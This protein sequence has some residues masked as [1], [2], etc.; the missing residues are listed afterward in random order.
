MKIVQTFD[1][2]SESNLLTDSFGWYAPEY[3]LMSWA[4]SCLQLK[5]FY[6]NVCL[7]TNE[8]GAKWLGDI[9]QLPYRNIYLSHSAFS[10]PHEDLWALPKIYTYSQQNEPFLHVDGDVF[11]FKAF[12]EDLI[13]QPLIAQN[14][15]VATDYYASVQKQ[16]QQHFRYLPE[17]VSN[18]FKCS[19]PIRAVNA[20]ILGGTDITFY[21]KYT[22][23]AFEYVNRNMDVLSYV[24]VNRL[25]VFVEQHLFCCYA[26][27]CNKP[28]AYLIDK[29]FEDNTYKNLANFWE[30]PYKQS[31]LHLLGEFKKNKFV[32]I[33]MAAT[34][35]HLYPDYYYQ[36]IALFKNENIPLAH[37]YYFKNKYYDKDKLKKYYSD[38]ITIYNNQQ[39]SEKNSLQPFDDILLKFTTLSK[40]HAFIKE[41]IENTPKGNT[42][43][44][45]NELEKD[46][47]DFLDQIVKF[48]QNKRLIQSE[49]FYGRDIKAVHWYRRIFDDSKKSFLKRVIKSD[50][51]E[52]IFTSF[53]WGAL[54]CKCH[55]IG[56][57][58]YKTIKLEKGKYPAILISEADKTGVSIFDLETLEVN[59]LNV[60]TR[61][62]KIETLLHRF[63]DCFETSVIEQNL[64]DIQQLMFKLLKR[65][66]LLKAVKPLKDV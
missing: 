8:K 46:Y 22:D 34:L 58:Y 31:Y 49:F 65:L 38:S 59:L 56:T 15:E 6:H 42:G 36:I 5:K 47:Q 63:K 61:P 54:W 52:V 17:V 43:I 60:M 29:V 45:K 9:L 62:V 20:G 4:L 11:I 44:R 35:R 19:E 51:A 39:K 40:E 66:I 1:I 57:P 64:S 48:L 23:L 18:D 2:S 21:K 27:F 25:N 14:E 26:K 33:Q 30:T 12:S 55:Q 13:Q 50:E 53:N 32:C 3:H 37:D 28:V 41:L 10:R 16:I 24:N 7:Y